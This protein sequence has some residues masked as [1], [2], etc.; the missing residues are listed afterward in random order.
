M[1][2]SAVLLAVLAVILSGCMF[3]Q[4]QRSKNS[5]PNEIQLQSVQLAVEQY[6]E[7][8][9]GL[10]PIDTKPGDTPIFQKYVIDFSKLK[11]TGLI[12]DIPGTAF[13]NGGH[14]QYVLLHPEDNP[15]V[16]LI[17][18]RIAEGLR[19]VQYKL[20][21]YRNR[22]LYPPFGEEIAEGIYKVNYKKLGLETAPYIESPYSE[23]KLPIVMDVQGNLYVDYSADLYTELRKGSHNYQNGEDIRYLLADNYPFVPVHS[24]P[25]TVKN[26]EPVF[27]E[28]NVQ[29]N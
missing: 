28:G 17:D 14:Y 2:R 7:D 6:K 18:L 21:I 15:T 27:F 19:E 11:E 22:N 29:K 13:E 12:S 3:P 8:T 16:K 26:G 5:A 25:Y 1:K 20:R 4:E 9:N 24:L 10:V 23:N